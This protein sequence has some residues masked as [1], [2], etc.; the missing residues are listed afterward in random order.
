MSVLVDTGVLYA[1]ADADDTHH[2]ACLRWRTSTTEHLLVPTP[3]ITEAAWLIGTRGGPEAEARFLESLVPGGRFGIAELDPGHDLPR[4]A[5]LVRTYA[6]LPLGTVD[7]AV[8]AT[9]ERLGITEIA[10][11]DRRDF[12]IVRPRHVATFTLLPEPG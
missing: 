5:E 2:A 8:V 1:L 12:A 11:V 6:N 4:I 9:A 3:V 7:A 10:T